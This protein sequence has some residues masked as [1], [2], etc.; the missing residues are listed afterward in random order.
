MEYKIVK[1]KKV[2]DLE[3]NV[4]VLLEQGWMPVGGLVVIDSREDDPKRMF[5][6][7]MLKN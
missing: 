2:S 4:K 1:E 3:E 5:F 7:T 6:Q